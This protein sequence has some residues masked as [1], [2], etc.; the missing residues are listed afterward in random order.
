MTDRQECVLSASPPQPQRAKH[1]LLLYDYAEPK[2][3]IMIKKLYWP[4]N[5][6]WMHEQPCQVTQK[7]TFYI[8]Y[9]HHETQQ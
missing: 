3:L 4:W 7:I 5:H 1:G 2:S 6:D 9:L 8:R